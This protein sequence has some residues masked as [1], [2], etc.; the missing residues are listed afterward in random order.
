MRKLYAVIDKDGNLRGGGYRS[1][2]VLRMKAGAT[3]RLKRIQ[4]P[5][6]KY[7]TT[8]GKSEPTGEIYNKD[9]QV[10]ELK[11]EAVPLPRVAKVEIPAEHFESLSVA[12]T[13]MGGKIL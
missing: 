13:S 3:R 7:N 6:Y 8:L 9:V 12:I 2:P 5:V 1:S 10:V 11:W 4:R